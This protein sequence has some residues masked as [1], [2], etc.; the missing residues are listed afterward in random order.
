MALI[1]IPPDKTGEIAMLINKFHDETGA[2]L[3]DR[4]TRL[5]KAVNPSK[6]QFFEDARIG[7]NGA[8]LLQLLRA[9]IQFVA[10]LYPTRMNAMMANADQYLNIRQ[11]GRVTYDPPPVF[12]MPLGYGLTIGESLAIVL[13]ANNRTQSYTVA[14]LP[15]GMTFDGVNTISGTPTTVGDYNVTI[16]AIARRATSGPQTLAISVYPIPEPPPPD[17][18]TPDP[19][20]PVDPV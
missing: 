2:F 14:N 16:E 8:Q 11:D 4:L 20:P 9:H 15:D 17:E 10:T 18:N 5:L 7:T 1:P 6:E 13:S 12:L 19:D 3:A